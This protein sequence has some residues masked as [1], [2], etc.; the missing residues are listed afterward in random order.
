VAQLQRR[1]LSLLGLGGLLC[2]ASCDACGKGAAELNTDSGPTIRFARI[3]DD[4]IGLQ[5]ELSDKWTPSI[6]SA[7]PESTVVDARYFAPMDGLAVRPRFIIT[8]SARPPE[9]TLSLEA[10]VERTI[11]STKSS[12]ASPNVKI[13]RVSTKSWKV[14]GVDVAS[15]EIGYVV[16]HPT[17]EAESMVIQKSLVA[18]RSNASGDSFAVEITASFVDN[19]DHTIGDEVESVLKSLKFSLVKD[20]DKP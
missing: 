15:F 19:D 1:T 4:E 20:N 7:Q 18:Y 14:D 12:L 8:K 16:T 13:R 3:S 17:N 5:V 2:L 6:D 10:Y 11:D 9:S